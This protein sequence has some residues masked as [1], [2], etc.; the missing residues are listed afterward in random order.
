MH[1]WWTLQATAWN[2]QDRIFRQISP[3]L[4]LPPI[5]LKVEG[6]VDGG[7]VVIGL[8]VEGAVD[9]GI[10]VIGLKVEGAV[11]GGGGGCRCWARCRHFLLACIGK[12]KY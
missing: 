6:V 2:S 11:D 8:K 5:G 10:V 3:F 1:V 12:E 7:I 4:C 9:G